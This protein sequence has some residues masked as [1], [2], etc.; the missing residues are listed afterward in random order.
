MEPARLF[1]LA[2][3]LAGTLWCAIDSTTAFDQIKTLQGDWKIQSGSKLLSFPVTYAPGSKGSI[4]TEQ[5]GKELS[6]F[7]PE[8]GDLNMIHFCNAG[9]QPH[10]RLNRQDSSPKRLVFDTVSVT[11]LPA[12]DK[13][14]VQHIIYDFVTPSTVNLEIVWEASK[15]R[16]SEKYVL[17]R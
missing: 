13:P 4:V 9:N 11:N 16:E 8:T 6:V 14:H 3:S 1:A 7:F 12:P 17:T 10:L 2:F 15:D 5:F